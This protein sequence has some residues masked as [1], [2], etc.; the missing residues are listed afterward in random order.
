MS[1]SMRILGIALILAIVA[2]LGYE[3]SKKVKAREHAFAQEASPGSASFT[4]ADRTAIAANADP[5][6]TGESTVLEVPLPPREDGDTASERTQADFAPATPDIRDWKGL[7]ETAMVSIILDNPPKNSGLDDGF[8][9]Q[10]RV[11]NETG[12]AVVDNEQPI[13]N[14]D[15]A[16][17]SEP[18]PATAQSPIPVAPRSTVNAE[19]AASPTEVT[20]PSLSP[21]AAPEA[22]DT[23]A[24][25]SPKRETD[26][27]RNAP[28][29]TPEI[30]ERILAFQQELTFPYELLDDNEIS[31][32]V[33][34]R[35]PAKCI[36]QAEANEIVIVRFRIT[37]SGRAFRPMIAATTNECLNSAAIS[38]ARRTR[39]NERLL[40]QRGYKGVDFILS[41]SMQR[42][43]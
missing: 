5:D 15:D 4:D 40:R 21:D 12:E 25:Q 22:R 6:A 33:M 27:L 9:E 20:A 18:A 43:G 11:E 37:S 1:T 8:V 28:E 34:P 36:E 14:A 7:E 26:P 10:L 16:V 3:R 30:V 38:A 32:R 31:R 19:T 35:F 42:P 41:Y 2:G 17:A 24:T 29:L 39:F 13:M 23:A